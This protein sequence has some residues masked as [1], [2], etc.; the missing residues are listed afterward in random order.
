MKIVIDTE[1]LFTFADKVSLLQYK[2]RRHKT[3]EGYY[4]DSWSSGKREYAFVSRTRVGAISK[5]AKDIFSKNG[6][7]ET[8]KD[9][10]ENTLLK[11]K[12]K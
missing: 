1:E 5:L 8:I 12:N 6:K 3:K 9:K 10:L 2:N 7:W 4:I 11:L